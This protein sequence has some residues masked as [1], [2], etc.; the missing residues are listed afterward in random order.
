MQRT[1]IAFIVQRQPLLSLYDVET[2]G[3]YIAS[4][5]ITKSRSMW[6]PSE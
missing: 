3:P 6:P 2:V 4:P 1:F 5:V